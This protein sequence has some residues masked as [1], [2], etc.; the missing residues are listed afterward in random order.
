MAP[1]YVIREF[2]YRCRHCGWEGPGRE[3]QTA[4]VH[5]QSGIVD[6]DCPTCHEWIAFSYPT[7]ESD[8][9]ALNE[10]AAFLA[11]I[12]TVLTPEER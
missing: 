8:A 11:S 6:Y 10:Y 9:R 4:E 12:P 5:E 3:L 1:H 7:P 2:D